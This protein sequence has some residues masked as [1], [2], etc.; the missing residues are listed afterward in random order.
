MIAIISLFFLN[1]A[2]AQTLFQMVQNKSFS[3]RTAIQCLFGFFALEAFLYFFLKSATEQEINFFYCI[4]PYLS[5]F[6]VG[7]LIWMNV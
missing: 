7:F 1:G 3:E 5:L 6:G 2:V 4:L